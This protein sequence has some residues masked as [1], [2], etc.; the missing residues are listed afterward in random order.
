MKKLTLIYMAILLSLALGAQ[1]FLNAFGET[2]KIFQ[3]ELK[4]EKIY[5]AFLDV[6][7]PTLQFDWEF[8]G[9]RFLNGDTV[10]T[11]NPF[12]TAS[13]GKT[14]T[15]TAIALLVEKDN[16]KFDDKIS[17]YLP[18]EVMKNLHVFEEKD[19]SSEITI[20][21]LLQHT[22]GL[23]DYFEG[24]TVDG[25]PNVIENIFFD[26]ARFWEPVE[27]IQFSKDK[28]KPHFPPG[29]GYLY[30]DTEYVLLGMII[31][32]VSGMALQ[33]FFQKHFFEP[34]KMENTWMNLRSEPLSETGKMAEFYA[35]DFECSS[36]TSLSADW[37]GGGIV[38]TSA[39]LITFQKALN[40][41]KLISKNTLKIMQNWI[42]ETQGM[43]YGFG[44]RKVVFNE[45][46]STLPNLN[47]IGH[48]GSTGSFMYYCPQ[49]DVYL[50]GTLDQTD[51]VQDA[52]VLVARILAII[53]NNKNN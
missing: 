48:S 36:M 49:L 21:Q 2:E 5:N 12:Y 23:P 40:S 28:M 25:S 11:A 31:E 20:A 29:S 43:Y 27:T 19:Y 41:G 22:S 14:F 24:E 39:D 46:S 38:S 8:S 15:A 9:G 26:T 37:A 47:V 42:P 52:T 7:S 16:I 4:K 10:T 1:D 53:H 30:S 44:L 13:I 33:D 6:C 17:Q 18:A 51:A 34:L 50:A 32:N 45:L 3:E 35:G